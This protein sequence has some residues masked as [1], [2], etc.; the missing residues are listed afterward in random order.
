MA[1]LP[2]L[3][4]R[5]PAVS[6]E[7][8]DAN[9]EMCKEQRHKHEF[10][11]GKATAHTPPEMSDKFSQDS[12]KILCNMPFRMLAPKLTKVTLQGIATIHGVSS[13]K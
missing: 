12:Y 8:R 2:E 5:L 11:P 7:A 4:V 6:D 3:P 10:L 1:P 9:N 13:P